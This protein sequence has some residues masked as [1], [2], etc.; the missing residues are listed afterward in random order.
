VELLTS[1]FSPSGR[2]L[3]MSYYT[4]ELVL[5]C[6]LQS[7]RFYELDNQAGPTEFLNFLDDQRAITVSHSASE[8]RVFVHDLASDSVQPLP[9]GAERVIEAEAASTDGNQ[10]ALLTE[11]GVVLWDVAS[12][13]RLANYYAPAES[14]GG[15]RWRADHALRRGDTAPSRRSVE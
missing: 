13:Q 11:D 6:D 1:T 8:S 3:A 15:G 4:Q 5:L 10:L 14:V 7:G 9:V 12:R 2:W